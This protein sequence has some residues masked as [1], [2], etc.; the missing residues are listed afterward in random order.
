MLLEL[1]VYNPFTRKKFTRKEN[2]RINISPKLVLL[3]NERYEKHQ[4]EKYA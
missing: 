3:T 2:A 1:F 4:K